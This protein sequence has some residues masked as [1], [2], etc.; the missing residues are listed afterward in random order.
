VFLS[1]HMLNDVEQLCD[2]VGVLHL[3]KIQFVGTP[4]E[5]RE[6]YAAETVEQAYLACLEV[7]A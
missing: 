1:T 4:A 2:R 6:T 5:F 7:A 3:G